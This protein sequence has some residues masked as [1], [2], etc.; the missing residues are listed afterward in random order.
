MDGAHVEKS[1][2]YLSFDHLK[3]NV[4]FQAEEQFYGL[5]ERFIL[6]PIYPNNIS[7]EL[8]VMELRFTNPN[9]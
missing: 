3:P 6:T 4:V 7:L 2:Y 8:S 1:S 9:P 5:P